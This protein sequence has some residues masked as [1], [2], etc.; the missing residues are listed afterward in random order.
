MDWLTAVQS[1]DL[2]MWAETL[3]WVLCFPP[4]ALAVWLVGGGFGAPWGIDR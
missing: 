3:M 1:Q 2:P 4:F